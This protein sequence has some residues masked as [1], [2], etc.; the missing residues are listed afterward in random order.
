MT[1]I[2]DIELAKRIRQNVLNVLD[3]WSS[4]EEQL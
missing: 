2:D 3:L 4:K 1:E